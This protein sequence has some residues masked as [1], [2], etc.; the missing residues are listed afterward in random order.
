MENRDASALLKAIEE[1]INR[2]YDMFS[3]TV[4]RL[5]QF[6]PDEEERATLGELRPKIAAGCKVHYHDGLKL[7]AMY[8][9]AY[10]W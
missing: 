4:K 2:E 9:K 10:D 7:M 1:A 6:V 3:G 8:R 5:K